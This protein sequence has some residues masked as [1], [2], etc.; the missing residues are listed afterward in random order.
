MDFGLRRFLELL[1]MSWS[2]TFHQS[3]APLGRLPDRICAG[4][5]TPYVWPA[6]YDTTI[7]LEKLT[8][9]TASVGNVE[10]GRPARRLRVG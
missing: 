8:R 5:L 9:Y 1:F 3:A 10:E 7:L 6:R 4:S 2:T